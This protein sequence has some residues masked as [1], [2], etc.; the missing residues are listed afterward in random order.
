[1]V[2]LFAALGFDTYIGDSRVL[3]GVIIRE[4]DQLADGL[5]RGLAGSRRAEDAAIG[6][7]PVERETSSVALRADK[8]E[9]PIRYSLSDVRI[10]IQEVINISTVSWQLL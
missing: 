9:F 4:H 5:E 2:V 8:L 7:L 1:M 3:R 10:E 6:T